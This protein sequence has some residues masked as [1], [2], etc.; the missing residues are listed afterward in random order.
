MGRAKKHILPFFI[1]H[2]GCPHQC[3]FCNQHHVS[4]SSGFPS[5]DEIA[6][7]I[8]TWDRAE[9]PEIAFYGGSFSGLDFSWQRYF[10]TPA[11]QALKEKKISGIR[12]ST[13]PDYI[14]PQILTFLKSF[15]VNTIELGVQSLDDQVLACAERG[16]TGKDVLDALD[17]LK[18]EG[19]ITGVQLM[20]GLPGDSPHKCIQGSLT[21]ARFQ[22]NLARIYPALV[23]KDTFLHKLFLEG[24]YQPLSLQEAV[25]ISRD[26]LAIFRLFGVEVIRTGLQPT[27]DLTPGEQLA[28]GPFHPAFGELVAAALVREHLTVL[29]RDF[30]TGRSE[31]IIILWGSPRDC[32]LM[33]G[34]KKENVI[35]LKDQFHLLHIKIVGSCTMERGSFGISLVD[36]E[37]PDFVLPERQFLLRYVNQRLMAI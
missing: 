23:L 17:L 6:A 24:S 27:K 25:E 37:Q 12:I 11:F 34:H 35:F 36:S 29:I 18:K 30:M 15:G 19:F 10:L 21:L 13:R 16:H 4:G 28:A 31:K 8:R 32:S 33:A 3:I 7:A 26:M 5:D 20:P 22:P 14:N 9:P 2:L 1:P